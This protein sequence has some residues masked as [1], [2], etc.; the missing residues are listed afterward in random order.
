MF[1]ATKC[2]ARFVRCTDAH[3]YWRL[4]AVVGF[5]GF[6]ELIRSI[7]VQVLEIVPR[8]IHMRRFASLLDA[9]SLSAEE[10]SSILEMLNNH[11]DLLGD[12]VVADLVALAPDL[13]LKAGKE[14]DGITAEGLYDPSLNIETTFRTHGYIPVWSTEEYAIQALNICSMSASAYAWQCF[15]ADDKMLSEKPIILHKETIG[16]KGSFQGIT[17]N[18]NYRGYGRWIYIFDEGS[19][20]GW[21]FI[22]FAAGS[23]YLRRHA[24]SQLDDDVFELIPA[25]SCDAF[26]Y[27][28]ELWSPKSKPH[29]NTG[30]VLL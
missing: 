9:S 22:E 3:A 29:T 8:D 16:P 24:F 12:Q 23:G 25:D 15:G 4:G 10:A 18:G 2:C 6:I 14:A 7:S 11:K 30:M 17:F 26:Y 28:E 1:L 21:M 27:N 5:V 20:T 13:V 19:G